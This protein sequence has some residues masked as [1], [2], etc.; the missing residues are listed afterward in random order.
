MRIGHASISENSNNGRDGR[1]KAGDQTGKEV[2]IRNFY[3]K[4]WKSLLRCKDKNKAEIMAKACES[5]CNNPNVG[6]D[7][8]QRLTLHDEL[9]KIGFDYSK[10]TTPCEC[11]CSSFMTVC[12]ECAGIKI[13]Y[14]SGNAP[15]TANMVKWFESTGEFEVITS[16]INKEDNLLRGDILVGAPNTHTVMVLDDGTPKHIRER[17]VLQYKTPLMTGTDV[18]FAQQL[19]LKAGYSLGKWGVDGEY[20]KVTAKA[21]KQLQMDN[22][23]QVDGK[24]GPQTWMV[25]EKY[26]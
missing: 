11:D 25:L 23:L 19:L 21:V 14:Q 6:Y 10:L 13:P 7:Q 20:G 12:A 22:H 17:R 24:I 16:G 3:S 8:S 4:P 18:R 2:C 9:V 26:S 5:I 15:V 1:A